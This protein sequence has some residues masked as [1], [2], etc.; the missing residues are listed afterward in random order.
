ML[1]V[2]LA[3]LMLASPAAPREPPRN[4]HVLARQEAMGKARAALDVLGAMAGGSMLFDANAAKVA[5]RTTGRIMRD[6]PGLFRRVATDAFARARP[7]VWS[8]RK[9]FR[10]KAQEARRAAARLDTRSESTLRRTLP[11]LVQACL[12]C[13]RNF[14]E[15]RD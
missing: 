7:D 6:L 14:R 9:D 10:V 5:R 2:V 4:P 11:R 3:A 1:A 12:A 8:R 13:H 15:D